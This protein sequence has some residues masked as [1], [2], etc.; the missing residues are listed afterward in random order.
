MTWRRSWRILSPYSAPA[1][2]QDRPLPPPYNVV[3]CRIPRQNVA[4]GPSYH[5]ARQATRRVGG[6]IQLAEFMLIR[7]GYRYSNG[8][9]RLNSAFPLSVRS[10]KNRWLLRLLPNPAL[11]RRTEEFWRTG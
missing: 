2:G 9:Q 4:G 1:T 8:A 10:V 5:K 3:Y 6:P 7:P 11:T